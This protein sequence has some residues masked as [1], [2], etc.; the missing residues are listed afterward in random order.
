MDMIRHY[1][2]S[3]RFDAILLIYQF[4]PFINQVIGIRYLKKRNPVVIG[5]SDKP[6]VICDLVLGSGSHS[7]NINGLG[8]F[9]AGS[10]LGDP[11]GTEKMYDEL[12]KLIV[13]LK[14]QRTGQLFFILLI[15]FKR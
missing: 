7:V 13:I 14:F 15:F 10:P 9:N 12:W 1:N 3:Q 4:E 5:K 8:F 2:K 11:A 6:C